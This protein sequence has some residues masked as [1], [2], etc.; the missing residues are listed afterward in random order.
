MTCGTFHAGSALDSSA[1][2]KLDDPAIA[3]PIDAASTNEITGVRTGPLSLF[4]VN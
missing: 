3:A 2:A 1:C 4:N